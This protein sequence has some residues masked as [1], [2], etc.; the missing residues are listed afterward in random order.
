[1]PSRI[2]GRPPQKGQASQGAAYPIGGTASM[3]D[4]FKTRYE[5]A[6]ELLFA[7]DSEGAIKELERIRSEC[8]ENSFRLDPYSEKRIRAALPL[9]YLR[10]GEQQNCSIHH[11]HRRPRCSAGI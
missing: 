8:E 11:S 4:Q 6:D 5:L 2:R 7:G 1:M 9:S 3:R 10:L